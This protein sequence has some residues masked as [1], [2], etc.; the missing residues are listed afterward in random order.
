MIISDALKKLPKVD[1]SGARPKEQQISH[2]SHQSHTP[3]AQIKHPKKKLATSYSLNSINLSNHSIKENSTPL[4][5]KVQ[6]PV[7]AII[8]RSILHS[9]ESKSQQPGP[10]SDF[11]T[12]SE[13]IFGVLGE[14][15]EEKEEEEEEKE[16]DQMNLEQLGIHTKFQ[17]YKAELVYS[18]VK[19]CEGYRSKEEAVDHEPLTSDLQDFQAVGFSKD[20]K[21]YSS[22]SQRPFKDA[23]FVVDDEEQ[24]NMSM[25]Q[26]S[27]HHAPYVYNAESIYS[28]VPDYYDNDHDNVETLDIVDDAEHFYTPR[29]ANT[30]L[31]N[32][33]DNQNN[34]FSTYDN[35]RKML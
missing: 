14:K 35:L 27:I 34:R 11:L 28:Q 10:L 3:P 7:Y 2:S 31:S 20:Y 24:L 22:N 9:K 1:T 32:Y 4:P 19:M 16:E 17:D 29:A 21:N 33:E 5:S 23:L 15:G 13:D 30:H 18:E 25:K 26:L 8:N 12:F 6:D